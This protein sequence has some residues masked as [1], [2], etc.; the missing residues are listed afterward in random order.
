M[1]SISLKSILQN[2]ASA[3][4]KSTL[5]PHLI[6]EALAG[7][8][9]TTTLCEGIRSAVLGQTSRIKPSPEQQAVWNSLFRSRGV[10]KSICMVAF[11]KSIRDELLKRL[12]TGCQAMTLHGLGFRTVNNTRRTEMREDRAERLLEEV[13]GR[14]ISELRRQNKTYVQ[15]TLSLA[16]LCKQNLVY[17]DDVDWSEELQKL[18]DHY[19]VDTNGSFTKIVETIPRLLKKM[20][21]LGTGMDYDDMIW[22][23]LVNDLPV[24]PY[25]LLLVD[26][27]QDLNAMQQALA[28][29]CGRRLVFCGDRHQAIYGFAGADSKSTQNIARVLG[30]T[31]QGVEILP[32]TV[33]RRC[34][35]KIVELAQKL[36]PEFQAHE[37]NSDGEVIDTLTISNSGVQKTDYRRIVKSEDMVLCRVT[38]PLVSECLRFVKEGRKALIQGRAMGISLIRLAEKIAKNVKIGQRELMSEEDRVLE[39]TQFSDGL[40]NWYREETAKENRKK[41]P[42]D[43]KLINLQDKMQC[44]SA[45]ASDA[46]SF[47]DLIQRIERLFS[48]KTQGSGILLSTIHR[49]KGLEANNVFILYPKGVSIPHPMAKSDWEI[50]QEWNL[51][52]VAQTRAVHKLYNVRH[53]AE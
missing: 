46:S 2:S 6:V 5:A 20:A 41:S 11:N 45:F 10:A 39:M 28:M 25:D 40:E 12:P 35:K 27:Y 49:A 52:Y 42:S 8:G 34:G 23:A 33:T 19:D 37:D 17:G 32:L 26:E 22:L 48:D 18:A 51:L 36:V 14:D 47:Q 38:A 3:K 53:F 29:K 16:S 24:S 50:E 9:K 43:A 31:E 15:A 30:E 13:C 21:Q 7:T 4:G 1:S 44:L